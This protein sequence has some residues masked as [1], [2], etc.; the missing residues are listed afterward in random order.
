MRKAIH[1]LAESV[2]ALQI[3]PTGNPSPNCVRIAMPKE[4]LPEALL[5]VRAALDAFDAA[6]GVS[7]DPAPADDVSKLRMAIDGLLR[8]VKMRGLGIEDAEDIVRT[9]LGKSKKRRKRLE[10]LPVFAPNGWRRAKK[11]KPTLRIATDSVTKSDIESDARKM[12][13]VLDEL[14]SAAPKPVDPASR[15]APATAS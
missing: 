15:P 4:H 5:E 10:P 8:Y 12:R 11:F 13:W 9:A 14:G 7:A 1:Q 6:G 2:R 3:E